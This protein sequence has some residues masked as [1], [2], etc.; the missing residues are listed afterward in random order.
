MKVT[1]ILHSSVSVEFP[2]AV[3]LFDYYDG[4]LPDFPKEKE[5]IVFASHRHHD[6]FDMKIFKLAKDR[7][8]TYVL[9]N[10]IK[11]SPSYLARKGVSEETAKRIVS[12]G[13]N[14]TMTLQIKGKPL[15]IETLASTDEGVAFLLEYDGK[16]LYHAGDL[17]WWTWIG[18]TEAEY[19]DMTRRFRGEMEKL[20]GRHFDAAF[21]PLDPRQEERYSWGFDA[22][23]RT[24][25]ADAVFPI[26]MWKDYRVIDRLLADPIS[27]PYREKVVK[28][29]EEG[30]EFFL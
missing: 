28:I 25:E 6:H 13:K 11:L 20:K 29:R 2:E 4:R 7:P 21:V 19:E 23:M 22:F 9:S 26:H 18:E 12:I 17:N 3:F 1:Y 27:E 5:L 30:E 10:D 24:A 15:F 16:T 14:R 8:V